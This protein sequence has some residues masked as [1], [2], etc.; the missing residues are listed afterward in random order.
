[1]SPPLILEL[2]RFADTP[3]G[4]FGR[5]H[6]GAGALMT[7]EPPWY[8]NMEDRSC[9]PAGCYRVERFASA[10]HGATWAVLGVPDR[11]AIL[12]HA[13]NTIVDTKGCIMPGRLLGTLEGKWAVLESQA[14]MRELAHHLDKAEGIVLS[15]TWE[16]PERQ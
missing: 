15:V 1:M 4:T 14:A 6:V 9:I 12:F 8:D 11:S 2:V 3:M 7:L 16:L 13:G 5:L 10:I